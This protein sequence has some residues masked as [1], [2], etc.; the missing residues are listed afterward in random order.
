[1]SNI[2]LRITYTG[3]SRVRSRGKHN[4][5]HDEPLRPDALGPDSAL[6]AH[7]GRQPRDIV[8]AEPF[9]PRA[10]HHHHQ[11]LLEA[12]T[13]RGVVHTSVPQVRRPAPAAAVARTG[14]R[15]VGL[16]RFGY[17]HARV[18]QAGERP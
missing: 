2:L 3:G 5:H 15:V 16:P 10:E 12:A 14:H 8:Q 4:A 17:H 1:V 7:R 11:R 6:R 9:E 18:H 13:V